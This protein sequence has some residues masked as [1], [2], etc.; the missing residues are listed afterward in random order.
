MRFGAVLIMVVGLGVV[1]GLAG[2]KKMTPT[3][4]ATEL[5]IEQLKSLDYDEYRET[6][7]YLSEMEEVST[8]MLIKGLKKR[9]E[10]V[11]SGCAEVLGRRRVQ[12]AV[13]PLLKKIKDRAR[14]QVRDGYTTITEICV[15]VEAIRALGRIGDRRAVEPLIEMLANSNSD[16]REAAIGA[17]G[18]LGDERAI[19]PLI[20][21]V[22]D[23]HMILGQYAGDVLYELTG[24]GYYDDYEAW[25]NWYE[26]EYGSLAMAID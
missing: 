5:A 4:H 16:F 12:M 11:R 19:A 26:S 21:R 13:E 14:F 3:E 17:L 9:D 20:E 7:V 10:G 6:V 22:R 18:D 2:C 8:A 25:K 23:R 1:L 24:Q 15:G